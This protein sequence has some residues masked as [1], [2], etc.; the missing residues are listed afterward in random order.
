MHALKDIAKE[1]GMRM[2]EGSHREFESEDYR[3]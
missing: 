3:W 1:D 2:Y